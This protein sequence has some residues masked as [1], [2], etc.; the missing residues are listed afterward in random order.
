MA[1][2][3]SH[4]TEPKHATTEAQRARRQRVVDGGLVLLRTRDYDKIQVKDVAEEANVVGSQS[5]RLVE[6]GGSVNRPRCSDVCET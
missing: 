6:C 2:R 4:V 3:G 5:A 1:Q